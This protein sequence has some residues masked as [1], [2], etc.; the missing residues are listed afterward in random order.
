MRLARR[1]CLNQKLKKK[2]RE[3]VNEKAA[4]YLFESKIE[5]SLRFEGKLK[6]ED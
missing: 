2:D 3:E 5:S 4:G 6:K 1:L